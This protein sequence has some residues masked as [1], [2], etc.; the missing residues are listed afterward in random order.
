[1]R[2]GIGEEFLKSRT[3][4]EILTAS[5][6]TGG[7]AIFFGAD[8]EKGIKIFQEAKIRLCPT[9]EFLRLREAHSSA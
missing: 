4:E 8:R 1:M 3:P 7:P 6:Y 2:L 5:G 9:D